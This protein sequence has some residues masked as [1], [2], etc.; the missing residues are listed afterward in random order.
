MNYVD[1]Y[2]T[3]F[4]DNVDGYL[5]RLEEC[6][7]HL[8]MDK[9][10]F[11]NK[12]LIRIASSINVIHSDLTDKQIHAKEAFSFMQKS[13]SIIEIEKKGF[14]ASLTELHSV[15]SVF[16]VFNE[17][18]TNE[19]FFWLLDSNSKK[20]RSVVFNE[21]NYNGVAS[22]NKINELLDTYE[23]TLLTL[24]EIETNFAWYF[25]KMIGHNDTF[26]ES[27]VDI[28]LYERGKFKGVSILSYD[29]KE[30]IFSG[31]TY[32]IEQ[33]QDHQLYSYYAQDCEFSLEVGKS[34]GDLI[35]WIEV[36]LPEHLI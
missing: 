14:K 4:S 18:V 7:V 20:N 24:N 9:E 32:T 30:Q 27:R 16:K 11:T 5:K 25:K 36:Y 8:E 19:N 26:T 2:G 3:R 1:E 34:Y 12:E 33:H 23:K 10:A 17:N 6:R 31:R 15:K 28:S 35:R 22:P 13:L 21:H 29:W